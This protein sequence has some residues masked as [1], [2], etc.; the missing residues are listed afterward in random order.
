MRYWLIAVSAISLTP[1]GSG[2][3]LAALSA[4][5][6]IVTYPAASAAQLTGPTSVPG[7]YGA[8]PAYKALPKAWI[9]LTVNFSPV[10]NDRN[11]AA[12]TTV[13]LVLTS[14]KGERIVSGEHFRSA[15]DLETVSKDRRLTFQD[16]PTQLPLQLRISIRSKSGAVVC[17]Y[18]GS[19][20]LHYPDK[21]R[22]AQL[23]AARALEESGYLG[24]FVV[25][26]V[27]ANITRRVGTSY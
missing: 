27:G 7:Y 16:A 1:L 25:D 3:R 6:A 23:G 11:N 15:A 4:A 8:G 20:V 9:R 10:G 5:L 21:A 13:E 12:T 18:V 26:Q 19:Y 22:T 14:D 17:T 2:P 24:D